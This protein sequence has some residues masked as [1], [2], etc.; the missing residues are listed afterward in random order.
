MMCPICDSTRKTNETKDEFFKCAKCDLLC[1]ISEIDGI[2]K[3]GTASGY[4]MKI[5]SRE[6]GGID[7]DLTDSY[8]G[9]EL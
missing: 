6:A 3:K 1:R 7:W 9:M 8:R 2:R 4:R 5:W